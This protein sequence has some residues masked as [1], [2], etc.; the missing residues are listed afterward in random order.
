M[1]KFH[2]DEHYVV[3]RSKRDGSYDHVDLRT[4][5]SVL[6]AIPS[7]APQTGR[8]DSGDVAALHAQI[9]RMARDQQAVVA[10]LTDLR[11]IVNAILSADVVASVRVA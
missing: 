10:E 5:D 1:S 7:T 3:V 6:D 8:S 9:E 2:P 4:L 11:R